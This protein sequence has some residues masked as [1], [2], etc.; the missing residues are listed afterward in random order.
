MGS[1]L[2]D[3]TSSVA[4]VRSLSCSPAE[5]NRPN[6]A[7]ASVDPTMAPIS[8]DSSQLRSSRKCVTRPV[9]P[10]VST[11]PTVASDSAGPRLTRNVSRRAPWPPSKMMM[12]NAR[13]PNRKA[14]LTL[15]KRSPPTPSSPASMPSTRNTSSTGA[16]TRRD[17]PLATTH[18]SASRAPQKIMLLVSSIGFTGSRAPV[19]AS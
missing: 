17:K 1:L 9:M 5:R 18:S 12:A 4:L 8:S 10:A 13:L 19:S 2:P 16:P 15:S 7:A 11:T 14:W 6:T 3:S